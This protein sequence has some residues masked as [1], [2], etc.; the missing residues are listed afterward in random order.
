MMPVTA[1]IATGNPHKLEEIS[2]ML[3][4]F[5]IQVKSMKEVGLEGRFHL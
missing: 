4:D 1:V 3:A 5:H 2:H